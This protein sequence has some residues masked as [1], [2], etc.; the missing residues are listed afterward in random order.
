MSK[1]AADVP[2]VSILEV[3]DWDRVRITGMTLD[4]RK[5][6][7]TTMTAPL[8]RVVDYTGTIGCAANPA[9]AKEHDEPLSIK[10][11]PDDGQDD[12]S[13]RGKVW[14]EEKNIERL[15]I[16]ERGDD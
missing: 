11:W 2:S 13:D 8:V 10:V 7:R 16:L 14:F 5:F 9:F 6:D 1:P 15:E 4:W 12:P 3:R